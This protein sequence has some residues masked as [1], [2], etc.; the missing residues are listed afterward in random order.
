MTCSASATTQSESKVGQGRKVSEAASLAAVFT[1]LI[2]SS[3]PTCCVFPHGL[4]HHTA[5]LMSSSP[6]PPLPPPC[7]R[8]RVTGASW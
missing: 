2:R 7:R 6:S 3:L 1:R 8:C 5:A 4:L